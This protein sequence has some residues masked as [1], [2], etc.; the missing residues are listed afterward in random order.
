M[1]LQVDLENFKN[2]YPEFYDFFKNTLKNSNSKF[3]TYSDEKIKCYYDIGF[4][5]MTSK[6]TQEYYDKLNTMVWDERK[7]EEYKKTR[8]TITLS[9]GKFSLSDQ[10]TKITDT[11]IPI[12]DDLISKKIFIEQIS[13][14]NED[15]DIINSIPNL[16]LIKEEYEKQKEMVNNLTMMFS[17]IEKKP[18]TPQEELNYLIKNEKYEDAKNF[19]KEHPELKIRDEDDIDDDDIEI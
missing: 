9:I 16:D 8:I 6:K 2:D 12:L 4:F 11:I 15:N 3:K 5:V 1:K 7:I 13:M 18:K 19:I 14:G 17:D 10:T